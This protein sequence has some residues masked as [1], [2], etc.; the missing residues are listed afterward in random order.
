EEFEVIKMKKNYRFF[1]FYSFYSLTIYFSHFIIYFFFLK[2]LNAGTVWIGIIGTFIVLTFLL[3][4]AYKK[5]GAKISVKVQ[6]AK[7]SLFLVNQM[8]K[9]RKKEKK[10]LV[11]K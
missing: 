4:F 10:L 7:I 2:K 3:R 5:Y 9:K 1:F 6:V 8:E 11:L